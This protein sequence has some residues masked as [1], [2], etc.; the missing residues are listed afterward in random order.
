M[1]NTAGTAAAL[2]AR[3][4]KALR[5]TFMSASSRRWRDVT[6]L[7]LGA[8]HRAAGVAPTGAGPGVRAVRRAH[9]KKHVDEELAFMRRQRLENSIAG[10]SVRRANLREQ[11]F[12]LGREMEQAHAPVGCIQAALDQPSRRELLDHQGDVRAIDAQTRRK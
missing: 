2:A 3:C 1:R 6:P 10:S 8:L 11:L 12:A 7:S 9:A 4:R 5:A